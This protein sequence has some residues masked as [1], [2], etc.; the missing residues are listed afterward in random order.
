MHM[1]SAYNPPVQVA[2]LADEISWL[3]SGM[4]E[5]DDDGGAEDIEAFL[6][7]KNIGDLLDD[8]KEIHVF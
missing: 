1:T 8:E 7:M 4:D 2:Q 5:S 3:E 6:M